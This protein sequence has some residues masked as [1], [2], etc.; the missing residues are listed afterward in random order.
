MVKKA[1]TRKKS[2]KKAARK[3]AAKPRRSAA[4]K[5]SK[6]MLAELNEVIARHGWQGEAAVVRPQDASKPTALVCPAGQCERLVSFPG[7]GG[8]IIT[9]PVCV[10]C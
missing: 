9:V 6:A 2:A 10:P 1:S 4:V 5:P 7:P 8:T 3:A